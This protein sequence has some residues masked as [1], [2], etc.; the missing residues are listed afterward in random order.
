MI[1]VFIGPVVEYHSGEEFLQAIHPE[2]RGCVVLDVRM[3]GISGLDVQAELKQR[4]SLLPVIVITGFADVP[5]AVRAMRQGALTFLEKPC[6]DQELWRNIEIALNQEQQLHTEHH[7]KQE[8]QADYNTL[9]T[10]EVLVLEKLLD[11][12]PNKTI[13]I[14]LDIGLRTVEM[15]RAMILKKMRVESLAELVRVIMI[16][17]N[18]K[19]SV[20]TQSSKG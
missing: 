17:R 18:N 13:A 12:F 3:T 19:S 9:T 7:R 11:G 4:G 6:A 15:R 8:I 2:Q 10:G 1:D 20:P 14:D 5:M 16:L